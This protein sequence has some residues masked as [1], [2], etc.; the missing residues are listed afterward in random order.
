MFTRKLAVVLVASLVFGSSL[1]FVS[2][3]E[4][5]EVPTVEVVTATPM[6]EPTVEPTP[7]PV[8]VPDPSPAPS[9]NDGAAAALVLVLAL[10]GAIERFVQMLKPAIEKLGLS[11]EGYNAVVIFVS[12]VLGIVM[13]LISNQQLNLLAGLPLIPPL[14]G[15]LI[16]GGAAGFGS[17]RKSVV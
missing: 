17:D 7:I 16:T 15:T 11:N 4:V 14:V 1:S 10:C 2:A 8:P 5:T 3:Q 12:V 6:P 13:V 9:P